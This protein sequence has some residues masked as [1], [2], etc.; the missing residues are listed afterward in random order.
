VTDAGGRRT[1]HRAGLAMLH[2][3]FIQFHEED[4]GN[5]LNG[6][7]P[8]DDRH[9]ISFVTKSAFMQDIGKESVTLKP[10]GSWPYFPA[11]T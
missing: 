11:A 7:S 6:G 4:F 10:S 1:N 9:T 5:R 8:V 3:L 2:P